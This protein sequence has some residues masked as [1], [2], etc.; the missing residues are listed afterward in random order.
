MFNST[1]RGLQNLQI[2]KSTNQQF[3]PQFVFHAPIH[4]LVK[5]RQTFAF[6]GPLSLLTASAAEPPAPNEDASSW[7]YPIDPP[8]LVI[9]QDDGT[10]RR[11][12]PQHS[13]FHSAR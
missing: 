11:V 3:T 6:L 7:A 9:P 4:F 2:N 5:F 1:I 8:G 13:R 12:P 10:L